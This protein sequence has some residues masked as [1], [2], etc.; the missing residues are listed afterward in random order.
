MLSFPL[1]SSFLSFPLGGHHLDTHDSSFMLENAD[2]ASLFI[3][4][5]I[6]ALESNDRSL[7]TGA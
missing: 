6:V 2:D 4:L 7:R 5:F 1:F 3:C